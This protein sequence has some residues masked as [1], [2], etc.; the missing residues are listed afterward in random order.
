MRASAGAIPSRDESRSRPSSEFFKQGT[1]GEVSFS[2]SISAGY[3]DPPS[4]SQRV[5]RTKIYPTCLGRDRQRETGRTRW[6]I[7]AVATG[8]AALSFGGPG[9]GNI[10]DAGDFG[11]EVA[12]EGAARVG[13]VQGLGCSNRLHLV[14][15]RSLR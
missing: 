3:D 15:K 10:T 12:S 13:V 9:D 14:C 6:R 5:L 2:A 4:S 11:V 7:N 8:D 1:H